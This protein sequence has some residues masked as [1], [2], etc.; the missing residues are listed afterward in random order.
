MKFDTVTQM[1][2]DYNGPISMDTARAIIKLLDES[3]RERDEAREVAR[4]FWC[5]LR[6]H[7]PH[8]DPAHVTQHDTSWLDQSGE[9]AR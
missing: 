3:R 9:D 5:L 4:D 1:L 8:M 2:Q 6:P 7:L